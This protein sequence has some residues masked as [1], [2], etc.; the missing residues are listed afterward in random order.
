MRI[1]FFKVG[2]NKLKGFI[3]RVPE[4]A[5]YTDYFIGFKHLKHHHGRCLRICFNFY[6]F[7]IKLIFDTWNLL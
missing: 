1:E 3:G 2:N 6:F 7:A 4:G 5:N